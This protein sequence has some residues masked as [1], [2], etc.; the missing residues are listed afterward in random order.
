MDIRTDTDQ[1]IHSWLHDEAA[2]IPTFE[3]GELVGGVH[4]VRQRR[5]RGRLWRALPAGVSRPASRRTRKLLLIGVVVLLTLA[6]LAAVMIVGS[7]RRPAPPVGPAGN[8]LI[9]Y[10]DGDDLYLL[11]LDGARTA[12]GLLGLG[13]EGNASFSPDGTQIAFFSRS[14]RSAADGPQRLFV[15]PVDGSAPARDVSGTVSVWNL[16]NVGAMPAWA[17]DGRHIAFAGF[18]FT[19]GDIGIAVARLEDRTVEFAARSRDGSAFTNPQWSPDGTWISFRSAGPDHGSPT[20]LVI[21]RADGSDRRDVA[22]VARQTLAFDEL[23]WSPD[24]RHVAY[25]RRE[26]VE[27][28]DHTVAVYD[29][30][31]EAETLLTPGAAGF[32]PAWSSDGQAIAYLEDR[33]EEGRVLVVVQPTGNNRRELGVVVDCSLSWSPDSQFILG[34][35][36][37][38]RDALVVVPVADPTTAI[39]LDAPDATGPVTWQRVAP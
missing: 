39:R 35:A 3:V 9:A 20:A 1:L 34:Y 28:R 32:S 38:C 13:H 26:S 24:S 16:D 7:E 27:R 22:T 11:G 4:R 29:I 31:A 12:S 25:T 37:R 30:D 15:A 17:P 18:E 21:A 10:S 5:L 14:P 8:G 23:A 6:A 36:P 2:V 33:D 19:S